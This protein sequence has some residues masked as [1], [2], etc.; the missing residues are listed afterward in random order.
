MTPEPFDKS[1][2]IHD[3]RDLYIKYGGQHHDLIEAEM[4]ALGHEDFHRRSLYR[5]YERGRVRAGWIEMYTFN[6]HLMEAEK[7]AA[8][9]AAKE[10][11]TAKSQAETENECAADTAGVSP[12]ANEPYDDGVRIDP[13]ESDFDDF[14]EW[15]EQV[16]PTM[17]WCWKHQIYLY[18]RLRRVTDGRCKRLMIFLPPRHGKSEL[19]TVRYTAWRLKQDPSMNVILGCYSQ[20]LANRFSRKIRRVLSDSFAAE[21]QRGLD[22]SSKCNS[23]MNYW[24]A[25]WR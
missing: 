25:S 6:T 22:S 11:A 17:T 24:R 13:A 3:C 20:D 10:S 19:V 15:L 7:T 2:K 4:R 23:K 1:Q 16:S 12:S 8:L 9:A 21:T 18:K 14:R 5:R